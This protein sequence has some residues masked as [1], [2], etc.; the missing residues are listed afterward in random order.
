MDHISAT[1][2]SVDGNPR[3]DTEASKVDE[4]D[5]KD[6]SDGPEQTR[7]HIAKKSAS[8]K[9]VSVTKNFLAKAGAP[10]V[11]SP[12]LAGEK[13][14]RTSFVIEN[15]CANIDSK[16]ELVQYLYS[17][18]FDRT[19]SSFGC[20]V[21]QWIEVVGTKDHEYDLK[22]WQGCW[23]RSQSGVESKQRFVSRLEHIILIVYSCH[24]ASDS[25]TPYRRR[26]PH[27]VWDSIGI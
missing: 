3:S 16:R 13:S 6:S 23:T 27:S 8:F 15:A 14:R 20:K 26:T 7:P 5:R 12:K 19:S 2:I 1:S 10:V 18:P 11:M 4:I 21:D 25:E 9:P 17:L 22:G 24:S